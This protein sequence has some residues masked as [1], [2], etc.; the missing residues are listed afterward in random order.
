MAG[1]AHPD[2]FE[3]RLTMRTRSGDHTVTYRDDHGYPESLDAL[4]DWIRAHSD[5]VPN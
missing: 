4:A 3:Y 5:P 1:A 2:A